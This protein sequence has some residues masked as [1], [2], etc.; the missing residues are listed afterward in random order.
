MACSWLRQPH[1]DRVWL[2]QNLRQALGRPAESADDES[3]RAGIEMLLE[4]LQLGNSETLRQAL[5]ILE[6][7]RR[8]LAGPPVEYHG[9]GHS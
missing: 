4:V 2:E 1:C 7:M 6:P 3:A 8:R 5:D 9:N